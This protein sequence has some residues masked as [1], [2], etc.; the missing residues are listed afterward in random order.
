MNSYSR[1][2]FL[3]KSGVA[4]SSLALMD[5]PGFFPDSIETAS[6]SLEEK[7]GQMLMIGFRGLEV[8]SSHTIVRDILARHIGSVLLF[9]YDV[10][11]ESSV[12]NVSSPSQLKNL[13]FDL[14]SFSKTVLLVAVDYEGGRIS[15]LKEKFDFPHT[16]SAL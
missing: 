14:Q 9:D 10:P 15:R 16:Y 8:D 6:V 7:I 11:R 13:I 3:K 4:F 2:A 1:R 5:K 12:R